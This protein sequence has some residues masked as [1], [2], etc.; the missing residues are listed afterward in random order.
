MPEH[1]PIRD[2]GDVVIEDPAEV[3]RIDKPERSADRELARRQARKKRRP[4][5]GRCCTPVGQQS[6]AGRARETRRAR[7]CQPEYRLKTGAAAMAD[8]A[9]PQRAT[10]PILR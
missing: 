1:V 3:D 8:C 9:Y 2:L 7:E 5:G 6:G 4:K 10:R